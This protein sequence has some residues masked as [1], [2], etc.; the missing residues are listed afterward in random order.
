MCSDVTRDRVYEVSIV[1]PCYNEEDAIAGVIERIL[2]YLKTFGSRVSSEIIAVDDGSS[3]ATANVL[4]DVSTKY[5]GTVRLVRHERNGG[6]TKAMR[7]GAEHARKDTVVFLDAD[8][9]YVP[10]IVGELLAA[11]R[12]SGA[13]LAIASPYM[14]GGRVGNVP[15]VRLAASRG[16]NFLLSLSIG[17]KVRTFTGMVRAYD[18]ALFQALAGKVNRGEFNSAMVAAVLAS[19]HGLVEI[20]A[21][22]VWPAQRA[23]APSR[24]SPTK[25]LQRARL[26]LETWRILRSAG[27][28]NVKIGQTG[29]LGLVTGPKG[30][31]AS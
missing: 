18:T 25:L 26:V 24:I 16:A 8:L 3:D 14:Q 10:E 9:S 21:A 17:R 31:Y 13:S 23:A 28:G 20:P 27:K 30:P 2:A 1:V 11:K 6:L 5:P 29:T 4:H 19:N 22:L 15:F 7:T 12:R